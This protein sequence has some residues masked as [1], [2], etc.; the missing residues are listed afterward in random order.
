MIPTVLLFLFAA[1]LPP[2]AGWSRSAPA[3]V[4]PVSVQSD[5][6]ALLVSA[7]NPTHFALS[8]ELFLQPGT[9]WRASARVKTNGSVLSKVFRGSRFVTVL[10]KTGF[11]ANVQL[12][13]QHSHAKT[14]PSKRFTL[15][16]Q[17]RNAFD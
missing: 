10:C 1:Q 12:S 7:E 15:F 11:L 16:I 14:K 6:P 3:K 17:A 13:F 4:P 5:G 2:V 9:M 8:H